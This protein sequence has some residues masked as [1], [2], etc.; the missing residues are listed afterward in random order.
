MTDVSVTVFKMKIHLLLRCILLTAAR[1]QAGVLG[2]QATLST[3]GGS[4]GSVQMGGEEKGRQEELGPDYNF[5]Q[6]MN[7]VWHRYCIGTAAFP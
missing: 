3:T 2:Q 7:A 6:R 4:G 5:L 1:C